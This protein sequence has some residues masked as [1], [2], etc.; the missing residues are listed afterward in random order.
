MGVK[1]F[2]FFVLTLAYI[3]ARANCLTDNTKV[4]GFLKFDGEK[5]VVADSVLLDKVLG[6]M[7]KKYPQ[8]K[9]KFLLCVLSDE[10]LSVYSDY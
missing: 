2:L 3:T 9:M 8:I 5:T 4:P 10:D 1:R 7:D 6:A